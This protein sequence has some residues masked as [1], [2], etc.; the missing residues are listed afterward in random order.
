MLEPN[1]EV[2]ILVELI[3]ILSNLK[4]PNFDY[5]KL[6]TS[7]GL[8]DFL[9]DKMNQSLVSHDYDYILLNCITAFSN[10]SL[11]SNS[12]KLISESM[13]FETILLIFDQKSMNQELML[14]TCYCVYSHLLNGPTRQK[15]LS[16]PS[17]FK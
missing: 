15:I 14:Q 6:L 4:I 10:F 11:D 1:L 5:L 8:K 2:E 3:R 17:N 12:A 9:L 16:L 13:L 7:Y